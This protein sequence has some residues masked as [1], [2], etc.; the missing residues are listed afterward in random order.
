MHL[1]LPS[2]WTDPGTKT[3]MPDAVAQIAN[4]ELRM[5]AGD[6]RIQVS[7]YSSLDS[8]NTARPV[9]VGQT[10]LT[11]GELAGIEPELLD[12]FY[13]V[14]LQQPEFFDS[15]LVDEEPEG[16]MAEAAEPEPTYVRGIAGAQGAPKGGA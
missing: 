7:F 16:L 13:S 10:T 14:L 9:S 6:A 1:K 8:L 4:V 2:D 15:V 11:P 3:P 5:R 12:T